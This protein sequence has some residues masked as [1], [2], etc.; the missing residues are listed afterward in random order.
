MDLSAVGTEKLQLSA[1]LRPHQHSPK[2]KGEQ[3]FS[4]G[5]LS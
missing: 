2:D 4:D 1:A 5:S 3:C